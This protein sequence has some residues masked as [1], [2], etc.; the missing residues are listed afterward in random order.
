MEIPSTPL[1]LAATEKNLPGLKNTLPLHKKQYVIHATSAQIMEYPELF[2]WG[3]EER[4][5]NIVENYLGLPVAYHGL[6]LRKDIANNIQ[7]KSRLWHLDMEDRRMCKII[8]YLNDVNDDGGP[9]EYIPKHLTSFLSHS[10]RYNY[11]YI[12]D[13]SVESFIPK[14]NWKSCTGAADTVII[15]DTASIFHRGKTPVETDR[16]TLFFDYTSRQPKHRYYCKSS[17]SQNNLLALEPILSK[18][19]KECIFWR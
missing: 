15:V 14:S 5:L 11:G 13:R 18:H 6:Y 1:I 9:F 3:A 12:Q 16:F 7:V 10:L 19:Q 4:L 2:L 8:I 17:L